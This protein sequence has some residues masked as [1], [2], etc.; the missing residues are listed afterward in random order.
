[1]PRLT[2]WSGSTLLSTKW[3]EEK[4]R[5][6]VICRWE[7][8]NNN[9]QLLTSTINMCSSL[10][11]RLCVCGFGVFGSDPGFGR[12]GLSLL[13]QQ[14][15]LA[16]VCKSLSGFLPVL[17]RLGSSNGDAVYRHGSSGSQTWLRLSDF[18]FDLWE[19]ERERKEI[20]LPVASQYM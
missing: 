20:L 1:M 10:T 12:L 7:L 5:L 4:I 17:L 9:S 18:Q 13:C 19:K 8:S 2:L 16:R 14:V 6:D 15:R 3:E 11:V